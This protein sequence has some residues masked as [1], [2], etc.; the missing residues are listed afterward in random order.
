VGLLAWRFVR[1]AGLPVSAVLLPGPH[2]WG[3]IQAVASRARRL[4]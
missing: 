1:H 4:S 2:L 3:D